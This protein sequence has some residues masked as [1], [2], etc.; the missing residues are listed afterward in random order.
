MSVQFPAALV[1]PDNTFR[2]F[3]QEQAFAG[4]DGT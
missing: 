2:V 4:S 1:W 3:Y